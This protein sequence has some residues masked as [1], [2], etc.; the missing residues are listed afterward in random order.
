VS[1]VSCAASLIEDENLL[2]AEKS[3]KMMWERFPTVI[4]WTGPTSVIV[5]K[6]HS[7]QALTSD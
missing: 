1:G 4:H 6:N 2:E 3:L 7:H 5:V